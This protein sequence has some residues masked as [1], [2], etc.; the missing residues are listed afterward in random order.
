[1]RCGNR[2][3]GVQGMYSETKKK[4]TTTQAI[5]VPGSTVMLMRDTFVVSVRNERI[6]ALE[7]A[8][9]W[10]KERRGE[11]GAVRASVQR[12]QAKSSNSGSWSSS[13]TKTAGRSGKSHRKV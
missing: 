9:V 6:I 2:S 1:M 12:Y 10:K 7:A 3:S 5:K 4:K 8:F 13:T 11:R